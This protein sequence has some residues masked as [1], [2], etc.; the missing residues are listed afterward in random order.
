MK[1]MMNHNLITLSTLLALAAF[2][3]G[4]GTLRPTSSHQQRHHTTPVIHSTPQEAASGVSEVPT[5]TVLQPSET[6]PFLETF[7]E[8]AGDLVP[9]GQEMPQLT[10]V[11]T[12]TLKENATPDTVAM[13]RQFAQVVEIS[14]TKWDALTDTEKEIA[15]IHELGHCVFHLAHTSEL[16]HESDGSWRPLSVMYPYLLT[17]YQYEENRDAYHTE[18]R[19]RII[20]TKAIMKR[21]E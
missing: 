21:G 1:T 2:M 17:D 13:C 6:L 12:F 18:Y 16:V 20:S 7:Q 5:V 15:I 3:T 14:N 8:V 11:D 10:F 9:S 19:N 4:C